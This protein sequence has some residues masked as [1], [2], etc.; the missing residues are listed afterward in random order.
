MYGTDDPSNQ[1]PRAEILRG[2]AAGLIEDEAELL[3]LEKHVLDCSVCA[4]Y[5]AGL[6]PGTVEKTVAMWVAN[7]NHTP[8]IEPS[9]YEI[10]EEIGRGGSGVVYKAR[11]VGL[12]RVLAW[13][14]LIS[15]SRASPAELARF[16]RE[17][18]ALAQLDHPQIVKV[19]DFG[20]QEGAPFLALEYVDGPTL[21]RRLERGPVEPRLVAQ[22]VRDLARAIDYS[23][24]RSVFH[25]DLKPQNILLAGSGRGTGDHQFVPKVVDF[26]LARFDTDSLFQTRT[27]ETLG[28]PA[29]LAPEMI[30]AKR[31]ETGGAAVDVYGLGAILYESLTGRT[32]FI[33]SSHLEILTAVAN[34]EPPSIRMLRHSVPGDL[35]VI[36]HRCLAKNPAQRFPTASALADDLD[37]FLAG[38]PIASR[39]VSGIER[40]FRWCRRN[41]WKAMAGSLLLLAILAIPAAGLYHNF[42]LRREKQTAQARYE[43]TRVTLWKMLNLLNTDQAASI[44]QL[45]DL[46]AKQTGEALTLFDELATFDPTSRSQLDLAKGKILAGTL[47]IVLGKADQAEAHLKHAVNVCEKL[48]GDPE[49]ASEAL[50]HLAEALNKLA[51]FQPS[52]ADP[53]RAVEYLERA[54]AIHRN[55]AERAP[56]DPV[57]RGGVAWSLMNLGS[58]MQ[59][60]GEREQSIPLYHEAIG[61]WDSLANASF[62]REECLQASAGTR[63][64]LASIHLEL[65]NSAD[66]QKGFR[67]ALETLERLFA[68]SPDN[69]SVV[70]DLTSGLLNYSNCLAAVDRLEEATAACTRARELLQT[71]LIQEPNRALLK[72]NLFLVTGNQANLLGANNQ[73]AEAAHVWKE[74]SEIAPN[75]NLTTYCQQMRLCCLAKLDEVDVVFSE[76]K[77]INESVLTPGEKFLQAVCFALL[78]DAHSRRAGQA[79]PE[80]TELAAGM[81]A[82]RAWELLQELKNDGHLDDD[83]RREHLNTSDD[84]SALRKIHTSEEWSGL[85]R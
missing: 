62:D 14:V 15:G 2:F 43:S 46:S 25:R 47:A 32:P 64:N 59:I 36:C 24:Q 55:L 60:Q 44:P 17:A 4:G 76:S 41:P 28:T 82:S 22:W 3:A 78:A 53:S 83:G 69:K 23:H 63:I 54:L 75:P 67:E 33:G 61:I 45:A 51:T 19:H 79:E 8:A 40:A 12:D 13:K 50:G 77:L 34:S 37:R 38:V 84:W 65:G 48:Q 74:A 7:G 58:A 26:G 30:G 72:Q 39:P 57:R 31:G 5:L 10:I 18:Q 73:L 85:V 56:D 66:A 27:G 81:A 11:Q 29:Y 16:Q 9:R 6:T 70:E 1:H 20:E 71:A 35:S 52:A 68:A 80:R 49:I 21:A 42:Q